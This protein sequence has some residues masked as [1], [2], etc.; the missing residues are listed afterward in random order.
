LGYVAKCW[1]VN[2]VVLKPGRE[3]IFQLRHHWIFSGAIASY[4]ESYQDGELV[5]ICSHTGL[6]LGWGFFNRRCSLAGRVVSFGE[7]E[8]FS[9]LKHT[10]SRALDL[11]KNFVR[12]GSACRLINGEG[13][14][15]PGLI[16]DQYGPYLVMQ[17][18]ALGMRKLLPFF[19]EEFKERLPIAGIYDKSTGASLK[20][21][22]M[23]PQEKL[24][25]GRVP[26]RVA[27]VE[28]GMKFYV[29]LKTGQ[30]TGFFLDQREMR[31]T[32]SS[33][34]KGRRVLNG[35]SYTG[36]FT[37]AAL[38]GGATFV[39]S[40]DISPTALALCKENVLANGFSHQNTRYIQ[41]DVFDYLSS[42]TCD[43]DLM[44]LDPPAFA[45]KKK[46]IPAAAK[47]YKRLFKLAM[48]KMCEKSILVV[49]SC[50]YY[51]SE[52][53]FEKIVF[54]AALE[55]LRPLCVIGRHR[56]AFDHPINLFHRESNYLKS[57]I[58][59]I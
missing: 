12:E 8:V 20:E 1:G 16:V 43:Y 37:I 49:S 18:G 29:D 57:L 32:V 51:L 31:K 26:D 24:L 7:Q 25:W 2:S 14:A 13:D 58:L 4:P 42:N 47:G 40:V 15:L 45:K 41:E 33:L 54:E 9:Q 5:P 21:E 52:E 44:I 39:D 34:A 48:Q 17:S 46:D 23:N 53:H 6:G 19:I 22:G 27:I 28:E 55:V 10:L 11:R 50:S 30:K 56:H 59:A 38:K 3:K 35:F 36:G